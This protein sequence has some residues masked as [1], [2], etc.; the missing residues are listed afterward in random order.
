MCGAQNGDGKPQ[1]KKQGTVDSSEH[2]AHTLA[3]K[4]LSGKVQHRCTI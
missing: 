4:I 1:W 2:F 3:D